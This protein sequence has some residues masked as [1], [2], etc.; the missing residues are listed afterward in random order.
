MLQHL[1]RCWCVLGHSCRR[2]GS[3]C[4]WRYSKAHPLF[5]TSVLTKVLPAHARV[6]VCRGEGWG[7]P[8]VE[9]MSMGLPVIAT[10]WSAMVDYLDESVGYPLAIDGLEPVPLEQW[11]KWA[12]PSVAHL[13]QLMRQVVEQ[14][15]EAAAR[16]AAARA[17]MQER[18]APEVVGRRVLARMQEI[19]SE[20][21]A[22]AGRASIS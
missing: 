21:P 5:N 15:G 7:L 16:G 20:L 18:Y 11:H 14:R 13:R 22:P 19:D 4:G 10:N 12:K 8:I 3:S 1:R 17:R 6:C 9:A 2:W